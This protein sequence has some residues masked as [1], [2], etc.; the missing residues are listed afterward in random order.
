MDGGENQCLS[1]HP[2]TAAEKEFLI[3]RYLFFTRA[4][5]IHWMDAGI[6]PEFKRKHEKSKL[7]PF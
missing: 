6:I 4:G 5:D 3:N 7:F 2:A 1:A